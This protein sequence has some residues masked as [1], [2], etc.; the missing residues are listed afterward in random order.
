MVACLSVLARLEI[1]S[2]RFESPQSHP[3]RNSL[4]LP[5]PTRA[6]L[7]VLIRLEFEGVSEY[8]EYI[9]ARIDVPVLHFLGITFFHQ[10]IFDTPQLTQLIDR[11]T[12]QTKTLDGAYLTFL[13]WDKNSSIMLFRQNCVFDDE[14]RLDI[15]CR[16][17][18]QSYWQFSFL[19]QMCSS[20]GPHYL[21]P[22]KEKLYV[23]LYASGTDPWQ[24]EID[25]GPWLEILRSFT[26]VKALYISDKLTP[27][28]AYALQELVGERV[29]EVLP[30]LQKL[31]FK[32]L[33]QFQVGPVRDAIDQFVAARQVTG[34]PV[35]IFRWQ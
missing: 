18:R 25:G 2:V 14:L 6:L 13:N 16:H 29:M 28:I 21:I 35:A 24:G 12:P 32:D 17:S 3:D 33:S 30:A 27:H 26:G 11:R 20:T 1:L 9:V 23:D 5:P 34:H 31:F 8:L 10:L 15:T 4:C 7:P 19:T 22:A